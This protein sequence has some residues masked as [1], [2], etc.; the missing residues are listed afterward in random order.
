MAAVEHAQLGVFEHRHVTR[1]AHAM[2]GQQDRV[3]RVG[4]AVFEM[5]VLL[6]GEVNRHFPR[7][8]RTDALSDWHRE[9]QQQQQQ[10]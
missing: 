6:P 3:L 4:Q 8:G 10:Q 9:Q 2:G 7:N 1:H 5:Y